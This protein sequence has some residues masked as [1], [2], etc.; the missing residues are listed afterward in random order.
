MTHPFSLHLKS[1]VGVG[2]GAKS[3]FISFRSPL[4]SF[5]PFFDQFFRFASDSSSIYSLF[6][7]TVLRK[8]L[9]PPILVV[10]LCFEV[11]IGG[12]FR[13]LGLFKL[14]WAGAELLLLLYCLFRNLFRRYTDGEALRLIAWLSDFFSVKILVLFLYLIVFSPFSG[15]RWF[16][17]R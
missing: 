13:V 10:D 15:E 8:S 5:L 11:E 4:S 3:I 1:G 17:N 14:L 7:V 9:L 6:F 12:E 16:S 2:T